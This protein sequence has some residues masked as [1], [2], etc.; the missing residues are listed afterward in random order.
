MFTAEDIFLHVSDSKSVQ[1]NKVR[2]AHVASARS[3]LCLP[4][5][6]IGDLIIKNEGLLGKRVSELQIY[7]ELH[8]VSAPGVATPGASQ[9]VACNPASELSPKSKFQGILYSQDETKKTELSWKS[10]GYICVNSGKLGIFD[11]EKLYTTMTLNKAGFER[12]IN[13][14]DESFGKIVE[15]EGE[16]QSNPF[17]IICHSGFGDGTYELFTLKQEDDKVIAVR[18]VFITEKEREFMKNSENLD[19]SDEET[20]EI[21]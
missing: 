6:W 10:E 5:N 16:E 9:G 3:F 13:L 1:R 11:A 17:G 18:V 19:N 2:R 4:G 15:I 8:M 14:D 21:E 12:M 20:S 7:H